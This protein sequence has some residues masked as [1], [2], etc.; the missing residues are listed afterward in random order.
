MARLAR[1]VAPDIPHHITQ[2][3]NRNQPVFFSDQDRKEYLRL[4]A[5]HARMNEV[6]IWAYCLMDNHV[7]FREGWRGYLWQGRFFSFPMDERHLI[8]AMRYVERN[9]VNARIVKRAEDYPWSSAAAHI[10]ARTDSIL[11]DCYL[12]RVI[13]DWSAFLAS[14]EES[15]KAGVENSMKTGRPLGSPDFISKLELRLDRSLAKRKPGRKP[16]QLVN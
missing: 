6:R 8:A 16:R 14:E 13:P 12:L 4:V 11:S 2:R 1:V 9:P 5:H 15:E 10:G 7:N 3:G